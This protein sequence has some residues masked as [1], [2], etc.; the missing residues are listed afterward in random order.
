MTTYED[1][2]FDDLDKAMAPL[3]GSCLDESVE[4]TVNSETFDCDI[5]GRGYKTKVLLK[6]HL[7][8]HSSMHKM[9]TVFQQPEGTR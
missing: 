7:R 9:Y 1:E 5:C 2:P 4:E 6:I 3:D 8:K